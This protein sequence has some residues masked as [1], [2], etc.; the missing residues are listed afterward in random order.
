M[1]RTEFVPQ[2]LLKG[3]LSQTKF[4]SPAKDSAYLIS[5]K[6]AMELGD[7]K[8]LEKLSE[9]LLDSYIKGEKAIGTMVFYMYGAIAAYHL[10]N[11]DKAVDYMEKALDFAEADNCYVILAENVYTA[12]PLMKEIGTP[13]AL[14]T[15]EMTEKYMA[16]KKL[17]AKDIQLIPLSKREREV[18]DL[19]CEGYT[20]EA[21]SK[22]LFVSHST[23]KKHMSS[24][25]SKLNVNKKSDAIAVYK[26]IKRKI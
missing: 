7:Y 1:G 22:I 14:K 26:T 16:T 10:G 6:I 18:M 24:A 15:V 20:A 3:D 23:I 21:I 12:I 5:A 4:M 9:R 19:V 17:Y 2:W 13:L 8:K 11:H 25:Y